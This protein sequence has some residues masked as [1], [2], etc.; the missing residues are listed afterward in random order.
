MQQQQQ[1]QQADGGRVQMVAKAVEEAMRAGLL[2]AALGESFEGETLT[3]RILNNFHAAQKSEAAD[4]SSTKRGAE[5]EALTPTNSTCTTDSPMKR[6]PSA[7]LESTSS[8]GGEQ[9]SLYTSS[10]DGSVKGGVQAGHKNKGAAR[11]K[12]IQQ[13][14]GRALPCWLSNNPSAIDAR[15]ECAA[16]QLQKPVRGPNRSGLCRDKL[17]ARGQQSLNAMEA[18]QGPQPL[19]LDILRA[20]GQNVLVGVGKQQSAPEQTYTIPAPPGLQPMAV[21]RAPSMPSPAFNAAPLPSQISDSAPLMFTPPP[22]LSPPSRAGD[23]TCAYL[24]SGKPGQKPQHRPAGL[25]PEDESPLFLPRPFSSGLQQE[26]IASQEDVAFIDTVYNRLDK[27]LPMVGSMGIPC[28][29][30]FGD[31]PLKIDFAS[32]ESLQLRG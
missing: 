6:S 24:L 23:A 17:R 16:E 29:A 1:L 4:N 14:Q 15:K 22:G 7:D 12:M 11:N 21:D 26:E 19:S 30:E 3:T 27:C 28:T 32:L 2:P 9:G 25:R 10:Q 20:K 18:G 31:E 13:N 8:Q 5:T